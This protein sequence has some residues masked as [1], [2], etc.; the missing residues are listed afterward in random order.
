M[1]DGIGFHG[2]RAVGSFH[3][4]L[5]MDC[6][7]IGTV[8]LILQGSGNQECYRKRQQLIIGQEGHRAVFDRI[9][10]KQSS[11]FAEFQNL[12]YRKTTFA[13]YSS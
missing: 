5:G 1:Q 9:F 12:Y 11:G 13:E 6:F 7:Q 10:L 8:D 2:H 3:D 4:V